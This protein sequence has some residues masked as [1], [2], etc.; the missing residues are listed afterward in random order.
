MIIRRAVPVYA[1]SL[2][3]ASRCHLGA[4]G[5]AAAAL[6]PRAVAAIAARRG[7]GKKK[8]RRRRKPPAAQALR[9]TG[10]DGWVR[11]APGHPW[12][13]PAVTGGPGHVPARPAVAVDGKERKL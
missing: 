5:A 3:E 2:I 13:D 6:S 8:G 1:S 4:G 7:G 11:A 12:L 10:D 9:A